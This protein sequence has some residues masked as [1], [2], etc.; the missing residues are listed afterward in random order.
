[1]TEAL[2]VRLF[3]FF[4][5]ASS[6]GGTEGLIER[7]TIVV[8]GAGVGLGVGCEEEGSASAS[9]C[10]CDE[11]EEG[12]EGK[13]SLR[14]V[15]SSW[16]IFPRWRRRR[17][18]GVGGRSDCHSMWCGVNY[19]VFCIRGVL[20]TR[21]SIPNQLFDPPDGGLWLEPHRPSFP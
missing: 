21:P 16:S 20:T 11:G 5:S 1:M 9:G 19:L 10:E 2:P 3:F 15:S 18:E 13:P 7:W 8:G 14:S 17:C 12:W 6:G 4:L